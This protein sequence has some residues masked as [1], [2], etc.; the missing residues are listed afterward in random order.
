MR[1]QKNFKKMKNLTALCALCLTVPAG[2]GGLSAIPAGAVNLPSGSAVQ[3]QDANDLQALAGQV[4]DLVNQERAKAGLPG[5]RSVPVLDA[6]AE[7]RSEELVSTFSHTRPDGTNCATILNE[8]GVNWRTTGEN[9]AYGYPDPESVMT[10]WMNSA[11]HQANILSANF[12]AIGVGVVSRNGVLYWTQVFAGGISENGTTPEQKPEQKPEQLPGQDQNL[13][14]ALS[15]WQEILENL[16]QRP[17]ENPPEE[18]VPSQPSDQPCIGEEC[19]V[20]ENPA[21]Q[22]FLSGLQSQCKDGTCQIQVFKPDS[23]NSCNSKT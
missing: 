10:G 12:D 6:C 20:T 7:K 4:V 5:L 15:N 19:P 9:I 13:R 11:G 2:M 1:Y 16:F 22:D 17:Q 23:L 3:N 21:F 14:P 8:Y 18:A